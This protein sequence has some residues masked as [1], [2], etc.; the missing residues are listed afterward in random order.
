MHELGVVFKVIDICENVANEN[1]IS[2][3][4]GV[5]LEIGEVSGIVNSYLEDAFKWAIKK[6]SI[7]KNAALT[8]ETIPGITLCTNCNNTYSTVT[9]AKICPH[10]GSDKTYLTSGNEFAVKEITV[11][12]A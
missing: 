5:T 1:S 8:I 7:M 2:S 3:I 10:C 6:S 12:E 11:D 9:Y 4:S